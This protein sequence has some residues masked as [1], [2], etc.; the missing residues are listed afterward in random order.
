MTL[1]NVGEAFGLTDAGTLLGSSPTARRS[2][3]PARRQAIA[4][5][6]ELWGKAWGG[7]DRAALLVKEAL[8]TSDLFRSATGDVLDRELL[9][10][11]TDLPVQWTGFARRT[12]VKDFKP[13]KLIDIL[14]GRTAL[15]VVP[16]LSEYPNAVHDTNEYEISV[17]KFGRRFG[18][19]FEASV[20]D[21]IDELKTIPEAFASAARIT[22]DTTANALIV[23]SA[24]APNPAFF[25]AG[26]GNAPVAKILDHTNLSDAITVVSTKEDTEGNLVVPNGL[27]LVVG[28]AQEM[29]AR[30][31]LNATE[32]RVTNG[33]KT[34]LEPNWL[35]GVVTL[36][37]N[38]RL[39]GTA[40]FVL[41]APTSARPAI[42]VAFLRGWETPDLRQQNLTGTRVGG[43]AISPDEGSFNEDGVYF[44]VRH[45]VGGATVDPIHTYAATGV[46]A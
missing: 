37:V 27:V 18:Y 1:S 17:Q 38:A 19:S 13:K 9:A 45:I 21:D 40:W 35:K 6:T 34:T 28:P 36:V 42:A 22:E 14:G 15:D 30:R 23:T 3:S 5:A 29:N 12:T 8:S 46:G 24:G 32:V 25:N 10:R 41:P 26:N 2:Y 16:E 33:S 43:G 7:S 39:K 31:I 20:N 11:Y 4:E 44:R